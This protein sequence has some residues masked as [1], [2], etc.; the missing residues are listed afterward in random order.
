MLFSK[1]KINV[2]I[3]NIPFKTE[4][5]D[6]FFKKLKGLMF[7]KTLPKNQGMIFPFSNEDYHI[8]WMMF[9][10]IPLDIIWINPEKRIVHI[11]KNARP[12]FNI[13]VPKKKARYVLE[14]NANLTERYGIK[15]GDNVR[16]TI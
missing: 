15:V 10:L 8:F 4:V 6:N 14:I 5:A 9:T 2:N 13:Y 16:F 7:R 12:G 11:E 3:N 1:R